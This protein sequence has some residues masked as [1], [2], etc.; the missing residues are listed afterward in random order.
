M[1]DIFSIIAKYLTVPDSYKSTFLSVTLFTLTR[2]SPLSVNNWDSFDFLI[3][4]PYCACTVF[5]NFVPGSTPA[6]TLTS[7][8]PVTTSPAL[9]LS[10]L[11]L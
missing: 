6:F 4:S 7:Y 2:I 3:T 9:I 1:F 10:I 8:V 11:A 5:N